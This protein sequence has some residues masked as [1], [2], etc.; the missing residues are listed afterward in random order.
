MFICSILS[1]FIFHKALRLKHYKMIIIIIIISAPKPLNVSALFCSSRAHHCGLRWGLRMFSVCLF[2]SLL[3]GFGL[4]GV[5]TPELGVCWSG[6][7]EGTISYIEPAAPSL[8]AVCV[9]DADALQTVVDV[10][11]G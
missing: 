6:P 5:C 7:V 11:L 2:R 4:C 3:G 10:F 1:I 9:S 8:R